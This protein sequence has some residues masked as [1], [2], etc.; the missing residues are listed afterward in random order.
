MDKIV[1]GI[2]DGKVVSGNQVLVSYAL[3]SCIGICLYDPQKRIAGM[4]HIILPGREYAANKENA[5]KFADDGVCELVK[6]MVGRGA[7]ENMLV[8]KIAGGARMFS[9][10]NIHMDIGEK[11]T[12]AV[13]L[14]LARKGI[15]LM[16]QDTGKNY[17]RT[18]FFYGENGKLEINSVRHALV[19]L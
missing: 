19:V 15:P 2:A 10:S 11:N 18:I 12:E 5:Y 6:E 9:S 1:V 8:A 13:K 14:S 7:R 3:G 4:A 17:G 16:A